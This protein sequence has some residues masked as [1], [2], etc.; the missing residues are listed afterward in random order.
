MVKIEVWDI[1]DLAMHS[2]G[3][4]SAV[5][6]SLGGAVSQDDVMA[7]LKRF[8]EEKIKEWCQRGKGSAKLRPLDATCIDV[9]TGAHGCIFVFDPT[10]RETF[11]YVK[12]QLEHVPLHVPIAIVANFRDM[13]ERAKESGADIVSAAEARVLASSLK[14]RRTADA[15]NANAN[16]TGQTADDGEV[17]DVVFFELSLLNCFG[18]KAL[19]HFFHIPF[20][21]LRCDS[22]R[23]KL[24]QAERE[25][26]ERESEVH[27]VISAQDYGSWIGALNQMMRAGNKGKKGSRAQSQL[28][29]PVEGKG[30]TQKLS[31]PIKS[32]SLKNDGGVLSPNANAKSAVSS[33][34]V[35]RKLDAVTAQQQQSN[36]QSSP[37]LPKRSTDVG[38]V[39]KGA[40][41]KIMVSMA[42]VTGQVSEQKGVLSKVEDFKVESNLDDFFGDMSDSEDDYTQDERTVMRE[43]ERILGMSGRPNGVE[44][45]TDDGS[46]S[47]SDIALSVKQNLPQNCRDEGSSSS[48]TDDDREDRGSKVSQTIRVAREEEDS[49]IKKENTQLPLPLDAQTHPTTESL[50]GSGGNT[51]QLGGSLDD[52]F[53]AA[54]DD[55]SESADSGSQDSAK[56]DSGGNGNLKSTGTDQ[57]NEI[58]TE[59]ATATRNVSVAE[60]LPDEALEEM[61]KALNSMMGSMQDTEEVFGALTMDEMGTQKQQQKKKKKKKKKKSND[62]SKESESAQKKKKKKKKKS[63]KKGG[64]AE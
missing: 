25:R 44:A 35:T 33:S 40:Q 49:S 59:S 1:V 7:G 13:V 56:K 26:Q 12:K 2:D 23:E 42:K 41:S 60:S 15:K 34:S 55:D 19:Y 45:G 61:K 14:K 52:S 27:R 37:T 10:R 5:D 30:P 11:E 3:I 21:K 18:L 39:D 16:A 63:R 29:L 58:G 8:D 62:S 53:F 50:V 4:L 24:A 6:K 20:A 28:R 47:D 36:A 31:K 22:Y 54:D 32:K 46:S 9:Y 38:R 43:K 51:F 17:S 57:V 64:E 48:S